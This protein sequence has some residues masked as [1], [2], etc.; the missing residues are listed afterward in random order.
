LGKEAIALK[1]TAKEKE[2]KMPDFLIVG[3]AKSGTTSLYYYLKQHPQIF[4]PDNKEPRFFSFAGEVKNE[5]EFFKRKNGIV[6]NYDEYLNLFDNAAITQ[7]LGEASTTY[8]YLHEKTIK[9]IKKYHPAWRNLKITIILR[10]PIDRAYSHFLNDDSLGHINLSFREVLEKWK[11]RELSL[12]NNY[13][14]YGFYF[15]QIKSYKNT[16]DRLKIY[17][18]EDL[19]S[20]PLFLVQD[21][22]DFLNVDAS[23]IPDTN[24]KYNLTTGSRFVGN[25]IYKPN[26]IK[27]TIKTFLPHNIRTKIK[28]KIVE[29]YAR[30]QQLE[31]REIDALKKIYREDILKLQDLIDRDLSQ[32]LEYNIDNKR[33]NCKKNSFK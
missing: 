3:A 4:M 32:W 15:N 10:N 14:D 20:N 5:E 12:F 1:T 8:L 2:I 28:N 23:F 22:F 25:L 21:I 33:D 18:F 17:L 11:S 24:L 13:I 19:G 29:N 26:L 9:N 6:K 27:G 30:K 31:D 7:I 16:F